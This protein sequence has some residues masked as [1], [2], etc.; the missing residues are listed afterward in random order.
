MT[1]CVFKRKW[2]SGISWG[3]VFFGGWDAN[4]KRVQISCQLPAFELPA[5]GVYAHGFNMCPWF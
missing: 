3:Y 2:K 5:V 1:G 4:G